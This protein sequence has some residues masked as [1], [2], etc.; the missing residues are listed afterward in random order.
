MEKLIRKAAS[1]S[2]LRMGVTKTYY[3]NGNLWTEQTY[4]KKHA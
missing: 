2:G 4:S 1:K 3:D